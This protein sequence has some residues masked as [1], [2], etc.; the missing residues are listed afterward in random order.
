LAQRLNNIRHFKGGRASTAD[1]TYHNAQDRAWFRS[2]I[3]M[4]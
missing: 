2:S 4:Y 1:N 3:R